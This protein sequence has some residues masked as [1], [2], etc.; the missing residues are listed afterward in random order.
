[1][2]IRDS[3]ITKCKSFYGCKLALVTLIS[4][5]I[6]RDQQVLKFWKSFFFE[7]HKNLKYVIV[8]EDDVWISFG[9]TVLKGVRIGA[10]S[11]ISAGSI[12]TNDVPPGSIYRNK[13]EPI[14][15]PLRT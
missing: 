12:V 15:E 2:C 10:K 9:V 14:I 4:G 13:I 3:C 11:V 6:E 1:M 7:V 8:I 5:Q